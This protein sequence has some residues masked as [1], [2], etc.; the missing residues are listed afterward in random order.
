MIGWLQSID[1]WLYHF[2]NQSWSNPFFDRLM[3]F[4]SD[5]P[6][7][8]C[9]LFCIFLCMVF[10]GGARGRICALMMILSLAV[11]NWLVGDMVKHAVGRVRPFHVVPGA[12]LRVGMGDSYSFPSS[13]AANWF[14]VTM[15]MLIYYRRTV[16][17]ML[18]LAALVGLSRIYNGVHYPSDVLAGALLGSGYTVAVIIIFDRLWQFL[19]PRWFPIWRAQLPSLANP[20]VL[21]SPPIDDATKTVRDAH[22]VRLGYVL[23]ALLLL[24]RLA[25]LAAG[26]I[27]LSED[28]AYQWLWSKHP[29]LSYYSKPPLIAYTQ[30]LGTHIWGDNEFGVRFFSPVIAAILSVLVLRFMAR[31][32]GGRTAFVL[33]IIVTATPLLGVGSVVMTVDPLSV[34]FWTAAMISGWAASGPSGTTRQWCWAGLWMGLGFLSKYTNLFQPVCWA[35][36][37]LL[38]PAAR[39]HLR[40]PGP[41]LALAIVVVCSMPVLIWNGQRHWITVAHVASDGA[42]GQKWHRT[43]TAEFLLAELGILNPVFFLGAVWAAIAFWRGGRRDPFQLYLFS[44]GAPLFILYLMVSFHSRVEYNWIAPSVVPLFCLMAAYWKEDWPRVARF[45]RPCLSAGI[46]VG[47]LAVVMAH[48]TNLISKLIHRRLPAPLDVLRRAH[49]WKEMAAIAGGALQKMESEG[50]PAFI[51]CQ[52]YGFT[53]QLSF[54]LPEARARVKTDPLVYYLDT[55]QPDNQFYYWPGYLGRAGQ[56]ALFIRELPRPR[57][58]PGWFSFWLNGQPEPYLEASSPPAPLPGELRQQF[59]SVNRLGAR[60]VVVTGQIMRRIELFECHNLRSH[61]QD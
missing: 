56:N 43:Y 13:H 33:V 10:Q 6:W 32:I 2:V 16:W 61:R 53:G 23:V 22:W 48:D 40:K 19:A 20:I 9:I 14:S 46:G 15:V 49:G 26:K 28:E 60:D 4:V 7:F 30:F 37:F 11:G 39:A 57:L 45:A 5:S 3:P 27:E 58:A 59:E 31:A 25:Y 44:M 1:V 18:P 12:I 54:Y 50:G 55:G 36:F 52:H 47:L 29:A 8:G 24:L 34:L 41:W 17:V 21:P 51:I 35:V 42:L 38:W